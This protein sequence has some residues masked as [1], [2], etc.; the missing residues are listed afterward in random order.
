MSSIPKLSFT[1]LLLRYLLV[2]NKFS[3]LMKNV[4]IVC[5]CKIISN[6]DYSKGSVITVYTTLE[7]FGTG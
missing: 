2:T 1:L 6:K 7:Y 5:F 3:E 4:H